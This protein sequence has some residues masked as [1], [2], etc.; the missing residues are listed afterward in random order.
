MLPHPVPFKKMTNIS[1]CS[2]SFSRI[3]VPQLPKS[4]SFVTERE[5]EQRDLPFMCLSN[6]L[7]GLSTI[8]VTR[9]FS[10]SFSLFEDF[11]FITLWIQNHFGSFMRTLNSSEAKKNAVK[12]NTFS[13]SSQKATLQRR[14]G[15]ERWGEKNEGCC[16]AVVSQGG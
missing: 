16:R 13:G 5:Q 3:S 9:C 11:S 4:V 15:R 6:T 2:K 8:F 1:V 10:I 14:T 7:P 12:S